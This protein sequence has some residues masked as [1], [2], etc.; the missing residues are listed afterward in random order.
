MAE[1]RIKIKNEKALLKKISQ[2]PEKMAIELQK[3]IAKVGV[4]TAGQVKSTI[5][6]GAGMWKSP[7]DTGQMRQGISAKTGRMKSTISSS[8]R[9]PYAFYVHEGTRRMRKR[10]FMSI[11][12][13]RKQKDIERFFNKAIENAIK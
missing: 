8:S 13:K 1:I 2:Y 3:A 4:Y 11:T 10:P 9:T 5:T 7:V 6:S 12:A